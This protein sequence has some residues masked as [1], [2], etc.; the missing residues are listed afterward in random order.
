MK[1]AKVDHHS[2]DS[3]LPSPEI[4]ARI[5]SSACNNNPWTIPD[6]PI[7]YH[8]QTKMS[9]ELPDLMSFIEGLPITAIDAY[10]TIPAAVAKTYHSASEFSKSKTHRKIAGLDQVIQNWFG[11]LRSLWSSHAAIPKPKTKQ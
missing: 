3:S 8:K 7:M 10:A 2:V 11:T 9:N 4:I 1:T 5:D 6:I